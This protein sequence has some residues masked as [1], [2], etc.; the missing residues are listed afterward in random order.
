MSV[1]VLFEHKTF[2]A[3]RNHS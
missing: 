3:C 1:S 2:I